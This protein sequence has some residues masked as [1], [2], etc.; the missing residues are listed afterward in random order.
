M[1]EEKLN[2]DNAWDWFRLILL[3][4]VDWQLSWLEQTIL[5]G[6]TIDKHW[7]KI[8]TGHQVTVFD[9]VDTVEGGMRQ[10]TRDVIIHLRDIY[11]ILFLR[12]D[13]QMALDIINDLEEE[14]EW[15]QLNIVL[16][17]YVLGPLQTAKPLLHYVVLMERYDL[18]RGLLA[19]ATSLHNEFKSNSF[20]S[21]WMN[22]QDEIGQTVLHI[23]VIQKR[24]SWAKWFVSN[25]ANPLIM[26]R[27]NKTPFHYAGSLSYYEIFWDKVN[28][29]P[30]LNDLLILNKDNT[31]IFKWLLE[32]GADPNLSNVFANA[33]NMPDHFKM[34]TY[35]GGDPSC[36]CPDESWDSDSIRDWLICGG[37]KCDLYSKLAFEHLHDFKS[38]EWICMLISLYHGLEDQAVKYAKVCSM[39]DFTK[40]YVLI[41]TLKA[42]QNL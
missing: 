11:E 23:A 7:H 34:L 2:V 38:A 22:M 41:K 37:G 20:L 18:V 4:D 3:T 36:I 17:A 42:K 33:I 40:Y 8:D 5:Y 25:H 6:V 24:E 15:M 21:G 1:F 13:V 32:K 30:I 28:A 27:Y 31:E 26:D 12:K 39:D 19:A 10:A 14:K 9:L 16:S 35:Y 29:S